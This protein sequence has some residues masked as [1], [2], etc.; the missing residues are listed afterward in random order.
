MVVDVAQGQQAGVAGL[1]QA[2]A[3][4]VGAALAVGDG[5]GQPRAGHALQEQR[6]RRQHFH[7]RQ[8]RLEL[9]GEV[10]LEVRPGLRAGNQLV[11]VGHHLAAVADAEAEAVATIEEG[12]EL[13]AG[14]RVEEDGLGPALAGAQHV[15]VGE[16]AAGRQAL[17]VV[18]RDAP[19]DDVAHVHVHRLEAGAVEGG[20]HL[21]LAVDA[22]L[23]QDGH[24][25]ARAGGNEGR[26]DVVLGV[27]AQVDVEAGVGLVETRGLFLFGAVGVVA[28][29]LQ[30]EGGLGPGLAEHHAVGAE[31]L[32]AVEVEAQ[33]VVL[34]DRADD[35]AVA[36][37]AGLTQPAQHLVH[38]AVA[39]LDHRA[40]LLAEQAG[41]GVVAEVVEQHVEA[42][43]AGEGHLAQG[44]EQAAVGAVVVGQ[45][46]APGVEL[47]D[48]PEEGLEGLRV[49]QVRRV[50]ADLLVDLRQGRAGEAVGALAQV[51]EDEIVADVAA[52]LRGEG[53]AHI[54]HRGEGGDHQRQRRGDRLL[55]AVLPPHG[56]HGHGV[57]A[58]RDADAQRRAQLHAHGAHGVEQAGV[59]A[60]VAGG[61]HPV[62]GELDVAQSLDARASDVG[63]GLG[64]RHARRGGVMHQGDGGAL[65]HGHG[66]AGVAA[67]VGGGHRH[68]GHR[69]LPGT[70]QLVA[71][72]QPGDGAVADGDQEALVA[73]RGQAQHAQG[74]LPRVDAGGV[75]AGL[76]EAVVVH[77]AQHLRRLAQQHLHGHVDGGGLR[78]AVEQAVAEDESFLLGG[79]ADH[80]EGAALALADGLELGQ[81]LGRDG[82]H[83]AL[84]GLVAPDL[85]GRHAG[86]VAGNGAQLEA[87]AAAA[88]VDDLGHGVGEAAGAHVVDG[89][90]GV[91]RAH[92]PA[93]VD[94]F[95]GTALHLRVAALHRGVVQ[96]LLA[97]AGGHA[98]GRTAAQADEHG[99]AAEDDELSA[100]GDDALLDVL[101]ADVAE[102]AGEHDGL[103][104][105]AHLLAGG[106]GHLLLE[107]AEITTNVGP[108]EFVVEG[109]G[110]DGA[111][112]HD[113]QRRDDAPGAAV[114]GLPGL[115]GVRQVQVG[116]GEAAQPGLGLGAAPG[117]ALVTDL[118]AGAGG[119]AGE[120]RDGGGVVVGLHLHQDVHV[121]GAVGVAA[122]ARIRQ[123][124]VAGVTPHHRGVVLVG[125][126]GAFG[127][128][129]L[130][131]A[132]HGE[133]GAVLLLAIDDPVGVEDLVA[134]VLGV[135]LGEHHQL[136]VTGVATQGGEVL[137]QVVDLVLGQ[138]QAHLGVGLLQRGAALAQQ[139]HAAQRRGFGLQEQ[140]LG[141][142]QVVQHALGHA[143][144]DQRPQQ[145]QFVVR[146]QPA[147]RAGETV[148][149][150]ALDAA[151][152]G[153]AAVVGD[154]GGLGRPGR[155]GAEA[156]YHQQH[157]ALGGGRHVV[158]RAVAQQALQHPAVVMVEG[159]FK[160]HEVHVLGADG[161][162]ARHGAAGAG[163]QL[164]ETERREG[165]G[166][167]ELKHWPFPVWLRMVGGTAY[168]TGKRSQ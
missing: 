16:A 87:R 42:A 15:A 75:E 127:G 145:G 107:A 131:V 76:V 152:L 71:R 57:L 59:L 25:R 147:V 154:V 100:G 49:V 121:L 48:H 118:A 24:A 14:A 44:G 93:A 114:V 36:A 137:Q 33:V 66:L 139:V 156:R 31:N 65:A 104:V 130:G 61:G 151:D 94:D 60:G 103:V 140:A 51:D 50:V 109:G 18:Q 122:A 144:V 84:L 142:V 38:V 128:F 125:G 7:Q 92:G 9:L 113:V 74:G 98:G 54:G 108:A 143:V 53:V 120:G 27:E 99:R 111:F 158:T 13:V 95:L 161:R 134:T 45:D 85:H 126:Q 160:I 79:L 91:V 78:G 129:L 105:A 162:Q 82:Q 3:V 96:V 41:D 112:D 97:L 8:A 46:H 83:V 77:L 148:E 166:A 165:S 132:D 124:A 117:G 26:G 68:V 115:R 149:H 52:Q 17:E 106:A 69:H 12:L 70:D 90:D 5:N 133:Q 6:L 29:A 73:H 138:G 64:H 141:L 110:T 62:G 55:L 89:D 4:E 23:A 167:T 20:G 63:D 2:A 30:V 168:G 157:L 19:G 43:A 39:H 22:L 11:Q 28:Q 58:H 40:R 88:V 67:V 37:Q 10:A 153:Q 164:V 150:A 155:D 146:E 116:D 47:L 80:R 32:A 72:H 135:G 119:G 81:A 136:H 86:V 1:T 159:K 21:Q 123:E 102:A 101:G 163:E 56:L 35:V 34:A